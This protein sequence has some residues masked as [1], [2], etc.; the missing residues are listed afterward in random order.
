MKTIELITVALTV[1]ATMAVT[2]CKEKKQQDV[3]YVPSPKEAPKPSAPVR[4]QPYTDKRDVQWLGK[5]YQVELKRTAS[6]S[7]RMVKDADGQKFVDNQISVVVRRADGSTA[8]S[9]RFTKANFEQYLD[10]EYRKHGILEGLVFD[11]VDEQQLVFAASVSLPQTDEYIP[12]VVRI[13]N[14]GNVTVKRDSE[15]DTNGGSE[16]EE[17]DV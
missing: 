9:K 12:L 3:I 5:T 8:I 13:D 6:D 16:E 11:K 10:E 17:D 15:M 14:F 4:M 1:A 7:L 2:G